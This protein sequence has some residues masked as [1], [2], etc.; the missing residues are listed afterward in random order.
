M[1]RKITWICKLCCFSQSEAV[2]LLCASTMSLHWAWAVTGTAMHFTIWRDSYDSIVVCAIDHIR[3]MKAYTGRAKESNRE[4]FRSVAWL[5]FWIIW[6]VR[7]LYLWTFILF[8]S[9][10]KINTLSKCII[11]ICTLLRSWR[12]KYYMV[13]HGSFPRRYT[14]ELPFCNWK[15]PLGGPARLP[16]RTAEFVKQKTKNWFGKLS[17][18]RAWVWVCVERQQIANFH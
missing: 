11:L 17:T 8:H 15:L 5:H 18:L 12:R 7:R 1:S 9:L 2:P 6:C 10:K 16:R 13:F 4:P 14:V 3:R